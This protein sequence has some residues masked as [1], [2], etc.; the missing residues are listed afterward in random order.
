MPD[1]TAADLV[2][3]SPIEGSI[4]RL[5]GKALQLWCR[6]TA[7]PGRAVLVDVLVNGHLFGRFVANEYRPDLAAA[8]KGAGLHGLTVDFSGSPLTTADGPVIVSACAADRP[9]EAFATMELRSTV[10]GSVE[11]SPLLVAHLKA[12]IPR[13]AEELQGRSQMGWGLCDVLALGHRAAAP[14]VEPAASKRLAASKVRISKYA[15]Y[16]RQRMNVQGRFDVD[17]SSIETDNFLK[18]YLESYVRVRAGARAPISAAELAYLNEPMIFGGQQY[19]LSRVTWMF[20]LDEP[21]ML[22]RLNL[23]SPDSYVE[24]VYWWSVLRSRDLWVDDCLVHPSYVQ[25]LSEVTSRWRLVEYPLSRFMELYF[26]RRVEWH[27]LDLEHEQDRCVYYALLLLDAAR[28]PSFLQFVP[29]LWLQTMLRDR[30]RDGSTLDHL[31][32]Q[33]MS[34]GPALRSVAEYGH[35]IK[36]IGFDLQSGKPTSMT[37]EGHRFPNIGLRPEVATVEPVSVQ[38]IGAIA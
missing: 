14:I 21:G 5:D 15:D 33:V 36:I 37:V 25:A 18:W 38:C 23:N 10:I 32:G 34:P 9:G 20:L 16:T 27:F 35:A 30:G 17:Q 11:L 22:G 6:D 31:A 1:G 13:L 26:N 2:S 3:V 8:G 29:R 24:I 19:H 4:D 12:H 28:Q 7:A